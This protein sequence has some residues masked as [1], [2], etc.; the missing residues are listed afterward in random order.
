MRSVPN[1]DSPIIKF[2]EWQHMQSHNRLLSNS[3]Y[4]PILH[5]T[6]REKMA[7]KNRAQFIDLLKGLALLVMIEVHVTNAFLSSDIKNL[8]WF[9]PLNFINGLVAPAFA[10]SSGM[11]FILSFQKGLYELRKFGIKFWKRLGRLILILLAGYSIHMSFLS[12]RKLSNPDYPHMLQDFF[13]VDILQC[14][15][16]GLLALL[17]LRIAIKSD[18]FFY[19]V[20]LT[21]TLIILLIGPAMWRIDFA[22]HIPLSI[23]N[24]F[25]RIHGSL[26]PLFPWSAFIF[27]GALAGKF[28]VEAK[29]KNEEAKFAGKITTLGAITFLISVLLL[30]YLL[31]SS[32]AEI[33]PNPLFF[34]ERLGTL[35]F[36]LGIFWFY[37]NRFDN[38]NSF[39]L[40]VSRE[41]LI[42]YWLHLKFIYKQ[43]WN[44]KSIV[45]ILGNDLNLLE[46]LIITIILAVIMI[47][48]AKGW[49]YLK[50]KY[51]TAISRLVFAGVTICVIIFFFD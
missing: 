24:Y 45:D 44:D 23:A 41:S 50:A 6:K 32:F 30:S 28:Y 42:V 16:V 39:V 51:P 7:Q 34:L 27:S 33:K 4:F 8:W 31:P 26:F 43:F 10:F 12:L 15:A 40:D 14:I 37:I 19:N 25:N 48:F 29:Q 35:F 20:L 36:L 3:D 1:D 21:L 22:K 17:F 13:I 2:F 5:K 18:K 9:S 49:G 38:Y 11:V 47:L 46:C